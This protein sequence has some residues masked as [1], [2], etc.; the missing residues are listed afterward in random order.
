MDWVDSVFIVH[1]H[2]QNRLTDTKLR[3]TVSWH[4]YKIFWRQFGYIDSLDFYYSN[5]PKLV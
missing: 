1:R 5:D 3:W 4:L 2:I